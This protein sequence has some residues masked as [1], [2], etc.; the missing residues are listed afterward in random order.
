MFYYR[1]GLI[2]DVVYDGIEGNSVFGTCIFASLNYLRVSEDTTRHRYKE[3]SNLPIF[4]ISLC[5]GEK[6]GQRIKEDARRSHFHHQRPK[7]SPFEASRRPDASARCRHQCGLY[8][9]RI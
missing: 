2:R 8:R 1:S 4:V 9:L 6:S 7:M 5:Y 3:R